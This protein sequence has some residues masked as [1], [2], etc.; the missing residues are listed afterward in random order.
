DS[1]RELQPVNNA[2]S[3][4]DNV[5]IQQVAGTMQKIARFQAVIQ[6][7]LKKNH[8]Y[9]VIN[10]T[11][12]PTLLKPGAE[13]ILMLMGLTSE[14]DII[15]KIEDY[16]KGIFAY[17]IKCTLYKNGQKITEGVGSCNSRE[18]KYRWRWVT[19]KDLPIG[20]DKSTLKSKTDSYGRIKYRVEN[21]DIC[22]IANTILKMAKKRAQIDATLTVA[23]LSEIFTQ[24][25]E[26]IAQF[27]QAEELETMT[28]N[29]AR[30][31]K[32]TF[33]KHK[34]QTLGEILEKDRTYIKWLVLNAKDEIVKKACKMLLANNPEDDA[35]SSTDEPDDFNIPVTDDECPF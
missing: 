29:E 18:D 26:D 5:D 4:I 27:H 34:G 13:K 25:V 15:E 20:I 17:T 6:K 22:S 21:D 11:S 33:G 3:I 30:N 24:D 32:L 1:T 8:D 12:K 2:L 23:S 19:E 7:T 9:G 10:G 35:A 31:I 16:E 28:E 14:Y